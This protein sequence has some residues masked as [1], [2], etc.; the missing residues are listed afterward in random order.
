MNTKTSN[1]AAPASP[2][3]PAAA[4][5]IQAATAKVNGGSVA[6]GKHRQ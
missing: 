2:M 5:R 6:K 1:P 4:S 3:T